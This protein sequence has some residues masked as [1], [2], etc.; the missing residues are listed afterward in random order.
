MNKA[1]KRTLIH[2]LWKQHPPLDRQVTCSSCPECGGSMVGDD[3][4]ADCIVLNESAKF[5]DPKAALLLNHYNELLTELRETERI[6]L[7]TK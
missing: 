4:C 1:A 7:E 3:E 5:K 2:R 6:I